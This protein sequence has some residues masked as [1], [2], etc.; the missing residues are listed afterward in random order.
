MFKTN[1][2]DMNICTG[3]NKSKI[4]TEHNKVA[5]KIAIIIHNKD[6][7]CLRLDLFFLRSIKIN[8][9]LLQHAGKTRSISIFFFEFKTCVP[10]RWVRE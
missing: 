3:Y 7:K 1:K 9:T 6:S 8:L 2:W 4:L 5:F 10:R